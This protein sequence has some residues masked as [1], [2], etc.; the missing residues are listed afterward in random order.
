[1]MT[2]H[3]RKGSL[4]LL[5]LHSPIST[6]IFS[7]QCGR[8]RFSDFLFF[9]LDGCHRESLESRSLG[10]AAAA[11]QMEDI[12]WHRRKKVKKKFQKTFFFSWTL[13]PNGG[14]R[15]SLVFSCPVCHVTLAVQQHS[16]SIVSLPPS[17]TISP[18]PFGL[19]TQSSGSLSSVTCSSSSMAKPNGTI[20]GSTWLVDQ[21]LLLLFLFKRL[22]V[23][24]DSK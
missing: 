1:M 3:E 7:I 15:V 12:H 21:Y 23:M 8:K 22:K 24:K 5:F 6:F 11:A 16:T 17:T 18:S 9:F 4:L 10:A 19:L 2:W 14:W 20:V 13:A